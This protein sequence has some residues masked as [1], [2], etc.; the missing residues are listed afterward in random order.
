V[1][2]GGGVREE[3]I[4]EI[5]HRAGVNEVHVRGTRPA[6]VAMASVGDGIRLRKPLPADEGV[7]EETDE[8][9]IR[10]FVR[11]ANG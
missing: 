1:M 9:R 6:S 4:Q 3:T 11:L 5:V 10:E 2:A 7:W 8:R